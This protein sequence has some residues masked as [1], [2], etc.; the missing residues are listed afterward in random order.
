MVHIAGNVAEEV[1]SRP[2]HDSAGFD[3]VAFQS[4]DLAGAK[5]RLNAAGVA[6]HEVWRPQ[7][8]ILQL[9]MYDPAGTKVELTFDP[10]EHPD[11]QP[12]EQ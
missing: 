9:V 12:S 4:N 2:G 8:E 7:L 3:H 11:R 10:A 6:W 5:A 1:A